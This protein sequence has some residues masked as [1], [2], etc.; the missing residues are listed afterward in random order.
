MYRIIR[1]VDDCLDEAGL[2]DECTSPRS[3]ISH[4]G[5][6]CEQYG[7]QHSTNG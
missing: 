4:E 3:G 2:P 1:R 7:E 6:E 5:N